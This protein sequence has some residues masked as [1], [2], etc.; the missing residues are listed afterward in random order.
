MSCTLNDLEVE[1]SVL[2]DKVITYAQEYMS[3]YDSSHNF[4]HVLRVLGLSRHIASVPCSR[5]L[6]S[7]NTRTSPP[8]S[9][10]LTITL[11]A[12]LHN[13]GDKKYLE[14]RESA[15]D[16]VYELLVPFGASKALAHKVQT[17]VTNVSFST[18]TKSAESQ[19]RRLVEEIP[20]LGIVQDADR[21]D[22]IGAVGIERSFTYRGKA[23]EIERGIATYDFPRSSAPLAHALLKSKHLLS[24]RKNHCQLFYHSCEAPMPEVP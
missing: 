16:I 10:H 1:D 7:S 4:N 6:P 17:I 19:I 24:S 15:D 21:L 18:K 23:R 8:K 2:F 14:P 9:D 5:T 13:V 3:R 11:S 22:A 12:L 20:E